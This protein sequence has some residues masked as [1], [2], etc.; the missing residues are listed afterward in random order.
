MVDNTI[1]SLD[2]QIV[3]FCKMGGQL[4]HESRQLSMSESRFVRVAAHDQGCFSSA[5]I[6][7]RISKAG[8]II[9]HVAH[10]QRR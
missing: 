4:D 7:A 8:L 2:M 3:Y 6:H 9:T 5:D 10:G 1:G